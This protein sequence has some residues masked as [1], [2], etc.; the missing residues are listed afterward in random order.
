MSELSNWLDEAWT[1][2]ETGC[3]DSAHPANRPALATSSQDG[4]QVR[5]VV[6]RAASRAMGQLDIHSD[7]RAAKVMQLL[8]DPR[9]ALHVWNPNDRL[10]VRI[11]ATAQ[12]HCNDEIAAHAFA[13]LPAHGTKIYQ[14]DSDPGMQTPA[15]EAVSYDGPA[16]FAL[17]RLE[18][19]AI[20]TLHLTRDIHQRAL[21][22]AADDWHGRWLVP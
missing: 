1:Q 2:L 16:Q 6:L 10:Q 18:V 5:T 8:A 4:P 20:E 21:F 3:G 13:A 19:T 11:S 9:A 22:T 14:L 12:L 7:A 17:I 15:P